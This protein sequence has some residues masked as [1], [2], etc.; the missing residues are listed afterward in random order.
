VH[1]NVSYEINIE[2]QLGFSTRTWT[3][4]DR[5]KKD[6]VE[7]RKIQPRS[8]ILT[9]GNKISTQFCDAK[10]ISISKGVQL[11]LS[12]YQHSKCYLSCRYLVL[13]HFANINFFVSYINL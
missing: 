6:S 9:T 7:H 8:N 2:A 10:V 5:R 4:I 3:F 13:H 12:F 11:F 1:G